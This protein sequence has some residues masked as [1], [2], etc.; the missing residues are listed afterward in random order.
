MN[1]PNGMV[2]YRG[3]YHLFYQYHPNGI[4]WGPMHWGHAVSS[5]LVRWRH[6]PIAMAPDDHLGAIFSGSVVVDKHNSSGLFPGGE[7]LVALFTHADKQQQQSLAYSMDEGLTWTK[8]AGNPVIANT[9]DDDIPNDFRDPKVSWNDEF[10]TWLMVLAVKDHAELWTAPDLIHWTKNSEFGLGKGC[11][12]GVWECP[13]L[14]RLPVQGD[15]AT[16]RWVLLASLNP[17]GPNQGG[18]ATQYFI[19]D[20]VQTDGKIRFESDQTTTKWLDYGKDNYA[21]VTWSNVE[22]GRALV[23]GWMSNWQYADKTPATTWRG[24]MTMTRELTLIRKSGEYWVASHPLAAYEPL[25]LQQLLAVDLLE[26][27]TPC[28]VGPDLAVSRVEAFFESPSPVFGL[29]L[30]TPAGA[31]LK[32]G[33]DRR[34][35]QVFIDRSGL[36]GEVFHWALGGKQVAP[37]PVGTEAAS[38]TAFLDESSVEVYFGDGTTVITDLVF[39]ER[40]FVELRGISE[41]GGGKV[42]LNVW[43]LG[44]IW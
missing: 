25:E 31:S 44:T 28:I 12:A 15:P 10:Q 18:S 21:G 16:R 4:V 35:L 13:D 24:A 6:L 7:G 37:Y 34:E 23:V 5:D 43:K 8:Y 33:F 26:C 29:E 36:G 14:F 39:P 9:P 32:I 30:R 41:A 40:R 11:T 17:G 1:D 20:L 19:G 27:G 2:F 3:V 22:E 42:D 38:F